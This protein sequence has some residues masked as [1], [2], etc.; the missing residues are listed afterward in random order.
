M[1]LF[2]LFCARVRWVRKSNKKTMRTI[3]TVQN[4]SNNYQSLK[5]DWLSELNSWAVGTLCHFVHKKQIPKF[6]T[7]IK[8]KVENLEEWS[9]KDVTTGIKTLLNTAGLVRF[10][11]KS[12]HPRLE[13]LRRMTSDPVRVQHKTRWSISSVLIVNLSGWSAAESKQETQASEMICFVE[14]LNTTQALC[15][16][17]EG[18]SW[19]TS[20]VNQRRR[21]W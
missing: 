8:E 7:N 11:F 13:V 20:L 14:T 4:N 17:G 5:P 16:S 12:K 6:K 1:F 2:Y 9:I 18:R 15:S 10:C 21:C 3:R 19:S